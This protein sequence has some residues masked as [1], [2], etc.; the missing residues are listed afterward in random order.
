[1]SMEQSNRPAGEGAGSQTWPAV[2]TA[3]LCAGRWL[4]DGL[5]K[6]HNDRGRLGRKLMGARV[7][8]GDDRRADLGRIESAGRVLIPRLAFAALVEFAQGF[9]GLLLPGE[10]HQRIVLAG[11]VE[12]RFGLERRQIPGR[13]RRGRRECGELVTARGPED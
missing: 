5:E 2:P 7:N 8:G 4:R 10:L 3:L 6:L 11:D 12:D 1:K 13:G 9:D